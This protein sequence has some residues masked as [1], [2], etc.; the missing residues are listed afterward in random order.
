[1][2]AGASENAQASLP[3]REALRTAYLE[4]L[5]LSLCDLAGTST[6]SVG[7]MQDRTVMSRELRG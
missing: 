6:H 5:K 3:D 4:L 7:A 1:M 2:A